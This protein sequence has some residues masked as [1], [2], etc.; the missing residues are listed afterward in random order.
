MISLNDLKI[1]KE[2][3]PEI[4][5][6]F[7]SGAWTREQGQKACSIVYNQLTSEEGKKLILTLHDSMEEKNGI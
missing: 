7:T 1:L 2:I 6:H 4:E 3:A 5:T